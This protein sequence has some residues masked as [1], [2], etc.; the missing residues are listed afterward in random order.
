M[1]N[2]HPPST[3]RHAG[4]RLV[5]GSA[6]ALSLALGLGGAGIMQAAQQPPAP[7]AGTPSVDIGATGAGTIGGASNGVAQD[8]AHGRHAL[9]EKSEPAQLLKGAR[10]W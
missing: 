2:H 10:A 4:V 5:T 8:V 3:T 9:L 7:P 1:A 6:I